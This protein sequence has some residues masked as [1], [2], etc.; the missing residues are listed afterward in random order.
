MKWKSYWPLQF[1]REVTEVSG[2]KEMVLQS[3]INKNQG[4]GDSFYTI[5]VSDR[6]KGSTLQIFTHDIVA[7]ANSRRESDPFSQCPKS[8]LIP[9]RRDI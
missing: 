2:S 1:N 3:E 5:S 8:A 6:M 9:N 4:N 7:T